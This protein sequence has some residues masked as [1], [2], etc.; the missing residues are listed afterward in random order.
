MTETFTPNRSSGL[1]RTLRQVTGVAASLLAT[2]IGLL[3]VT[4]IIARVVPIDPVLSILGERATEAQIAAERLRLGLDEPMWKQFGIY[5]W[6]A[7]QGDLG[8]SI[9]TREPVID[10]V[11]RYF[12][13]TLELATLA[14]ILGVLFG[15][16]AGVL[17]ATKPGSISDQLVRLVGLMGYS[18]PVFWLGLM[19]LLVFY[20]KLD[21]VGGP[22]RLDAGFEMVLE[23]EI[24]QHTGMILVDTALAG[25]WDMFWNAVSH[26]ILPAGILGYLSMAYI[27]RMT[28]SFMMNELGQEYITTARVK[29]MPE[30]RV[31]WVHAMRNVL[32]P[33]ITVVALSYAYLLEGAV[34][35]ETIFA[36]PGLGSYITDALQVNDMPAVLGG[37]VVVGVVYIGLNMLSDVLYKL[38]DPRARG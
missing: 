5:V 34:L 17:A 7:L 35:T 1:G 21:W 15:V 22:G 19:G 23:F 14:T 3:F 38:V 24:V 32:V 29:G 13:A 27:S 2:F 16:P 30:R 20:G 8:T 10:E 26:I 6:Q 25:R 4:F 11:L 31:I 33:L 18:M 37:T 28:R 9:R 36:W 12:P